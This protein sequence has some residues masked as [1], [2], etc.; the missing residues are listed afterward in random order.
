[1]NGAHRC[2]CTAACKSI[3]KEYTYPSTS[4][5]PALLY[6]LLSH[7]LLSATNTLYIIYYPHAMHYSTLAPRRTHS[8]CYV[9]RR[10]QTCSCV[11]CSYWYNE[12]WLRSR[13]SLCQYNNRVTRI[14]FE[15]CLKRTSK[16]QYLP[17]VFN[18]PKPTK[19]SVNLFTI[20]S[21]N[22]SF[23]LVSYTNTTVFGWL[24][25]VPHL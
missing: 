3:W 9:L 4:L 23:N 2:C 18:N 10:V 16:T 21:N 6:S 15:H 11:T 24:W 5:L 17:V 7:T 20:F 14:S 1:M 13:Y 19:T 12:W 8:A 25:P 22:L